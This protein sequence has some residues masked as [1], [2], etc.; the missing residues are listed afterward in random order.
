MILP[1]AETGASANPDSALV[2][3]VNNDDGIARQTVFLRERAEFAPLEAIQSFPSTDPKRAVMVFANCKHQVI[4]QA[5]SGR[6]SDESS[7]C[8]PVQPAPVRS[9]PKV[10]CMI[11]EDRERHVIRQTAFFVVRNDRRLVE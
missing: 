3:R 8:E 1:A 7:V 5:I 9:D 2:I 11:F 4:R 10:S 6:N